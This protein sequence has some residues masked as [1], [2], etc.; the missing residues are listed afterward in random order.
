MSTKMLL[1]LFSKKSSRLCKYTIFCYLKKGDFY[2]LQFCETK[3]FNA[4]SY[5]GLQNQNKT[6]YEPTWTFSNITFRVEIF[7]FFMPFGFIFIFQHPIS[8]GAKLIFFTFSPPQS[9]PDHSVWGV[10]FSPNRTPFRQTIFVIFFLPTPFGGR[11]SDVG[12]RCRQMG[13]TIFLRVK[14]TS[15]LSL[16]E[17]LK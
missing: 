15:V 8:S 17:C 9:L 1:L 12:F 6:I 5:K 13:F 16:S 4:F 7:L 10:R 11:F 14:T 3:F 2:F